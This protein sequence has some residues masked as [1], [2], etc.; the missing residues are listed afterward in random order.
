MDATVEKPDTKVALAYEG[1]RRREYELITK[2]L[3]VLPKVDGL[4]EDQVS[5]VRDALF[6]ADHPY[7]MVFVGPFSSGK[8]SLINALVGK[9]DLLMVG[10]VPTTDRISILRYGEQPEVMRA[11]ELDTVFHPSPL[12]QKVSF[13][14]TPGLESV[15]QK[16]EDVTRR[17]L[18]RADTVLLVMMATQAMT[19]RNLEYL[20]MLRAYGKNVILILNQVDLLSPEEQETVRQYVLDQSSLQL[21]FKPEIWMMSARLGLEARQ[22]DGTLDQ[23]KWHASGLDQLERYV[24][25][26]LGDMARLKQKLLTPLSITQNVHQLALTA[27]RANQSALDQYQAISQNLEQQLTVHKREQ[28]RIVRELSDAVTAKFTEASKRGTNAIR[29]MFRINRAFG[30]VGRGVL[31]IFGLARL[32]RGGSYTRA[33]FE[34]TKVFEPIQELPDVVDA[35][36]PRL[37]GKDIQDIDD[38]VKYA[39]KE[40]TL[41]PPPIQAKVIGDVKAP[42]GYDRSALQQVRGDL[43]RI[44]DEARTIETE[45]LELAV[46]NSLLVLAGYEILLVIFAVFAVLLNPSATSPD[47]PFLTIGLVMFFVGVGLLGLLVLPLRGRML[48]TQYANRLLGLQARYL[49]AFHKAADKQIAYGMSLR[50]EAIAPLT[51]LIDAQTTIQTGQMS[52]LQ[53]AGQEITSIEAELT[54]MGKSGILSGL[55]G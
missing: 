46:R 25:E 17:F 54:R 43:E 55:R 47:Q 31:E 39:R 16:H 30:S 36:A 50:R 53:A 23:E 13:V 40:I 15:F 44:E 51:R 34:T 26:Q 4:P 14:D 48:E 21:G 33:E 11:S 52:A 10:P 42:L 7:L 41:L 37:E 28:E 2:L 49:E 29:E 20:R 27:V 18:H 9:S 12:L 8:S 35:V 22:P 24:D 3:E 32:Q 1:I 19:A 45:K 5:Q 38:L 6:H